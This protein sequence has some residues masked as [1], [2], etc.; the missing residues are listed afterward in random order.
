MEIIVCST[1]W[2]RT[3]KKKNK[4][5]KKNIQRRIYLNGDELKFMK[6]IYIVQSNYWEWTV[7]YINSIDIIYTLEISLILN[8]YF[9]ICFN[10]TSAVL[11]I[12]QTI[13]S[14]WEKYNSY[15]STAL[16]NMN[17]IFP[18]NSRVDIE[19]IIEVKQ[20]KK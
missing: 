15:E 2:K 4:N 8:F 7:E 20:K 14:M 1:V 13:F 18:L 9:V 11:P 19:N 12:I 6:F 16:S 5:K 3:F 10:I 17:W